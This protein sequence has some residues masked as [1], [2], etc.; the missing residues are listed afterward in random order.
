MRNCTLWRFIFSTATWTAARKSH[1]I[2]LHC[3]FGV[4]LTMNYEFGEVFIDFGTFLPLFSLFFF[5]WLMYVRGWGFLFSCSPSNMC[6]MFFWRFCCA[7]WRRGE[8]GAKKRVEFPR[9]ADNNC[10]W[11]AIE[12]LFTY[13]IF[14]FELKI[15]SYSQQCRQRQ[16]S[17]F[18]IVSA[19]FVRHDDGLRFSVESFG[20]VDGPVKSW[21][22]H[23]NW[24]NFF[25]KIKTQD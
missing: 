5:F 9:W 14:T 19:F 25:V 18:F 17:F 11:H 8:K 1:H 15:S 23:E 10:L 24:R 21:N 3:Q 2:A 20:C 16:F 4:E 22:E 7:D 13:S 12:I 6:R